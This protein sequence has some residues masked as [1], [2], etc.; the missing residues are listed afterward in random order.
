MFKIMVVQVYGIATG[1]WLSQKT[2]T[3]NNRLANRACYAL[4]HP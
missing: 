3:H 1:V 4:G 2:L